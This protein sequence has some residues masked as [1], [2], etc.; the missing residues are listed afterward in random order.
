MD[1]KVSTEK[2][3]TALQMDMKITGSFVSIISDAIK[4][5]RPKITHT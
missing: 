5:A 2:G 1:F 4:K 3:I